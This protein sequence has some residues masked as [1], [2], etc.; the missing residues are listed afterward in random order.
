MRPM[1]TTPA[2]RARPGAVREHQR[3]GPDAAGAF[4]HAAHDGEG[5]GVQVGGRGPCRRDRAHEHVALVM[6]VLAGRVAQLAGQRIADLGEA[7]V[8]VLAE[9]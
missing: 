1:L 9:A 5:A 4:L 3:A 2:R 6:G 8:V 7:V